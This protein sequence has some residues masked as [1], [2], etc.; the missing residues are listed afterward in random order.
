MSSTT[1]TLGEIYE[2]T[3]LE[4]EDGIAALCEQV[5]SPA[6]H[7]YSCTDAEHSSSCVAPSTD[8]ISIGT[9]I[10]ECM[11]S[12]TEED[13]ELNESLSNMKIAP[14]ACNTAAPAPA[15]AC[16]DDE[17]A[18][19]SCKC[20]CDKNDH[21]CCSC[22]QD[23]NGC[24]ECPCKESGKCS[25]SCCNNNNKTGMTCCAEK[26]NI[27]LSLDQQ[28]Q[29]FEE[30][31]AAMGDQFAPSSTGTDTHA[32][33][34]PVIRNSIHSTYSELHNAAAPDLVHKMR[35]ALKDIPEVSE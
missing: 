33:G 14:A 5:T 9:L 6:D 29:A 30:Q 10:S 34:P 3:G 26:D 24:D 28:I 16:D 1:I 22:C 21:G 8:R 17:A 2:T 11:R 13:D 25:C 23:C 15:A 31:L 4:N 18:D 20:G 35:L 19:D 7:G 32:E 12:E 27:E